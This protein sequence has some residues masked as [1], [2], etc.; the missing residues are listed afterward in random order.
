MFKKLIFLVSFVFVLS[1]GITAQ[2]TPIPV[3]VNPA[4][5]TVVGEDGNVFPDQSYSTFL[6]QV[7]DHIDGITQG[8]RVTLISYDISGLKNN[9]KQRYRSMSLSV[10]GFI[11]GNVD[12][13][14]VVEDQDNI[15]GGLK[16]NNAPGVN[17]AQKVG[18][19]VELDMDDLTDKLFSFTAPKRDERKSIGACQALDDFINKHISRRWN[20]PE[21]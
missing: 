18:Y 4:V 2:A 13:Y 5:E 8:R 16:W 6:L 19:S 14:G 7:S 11:P 21:W 3:S 9:D 10:L 15:S 12:V 20:Y 17:N 1:T